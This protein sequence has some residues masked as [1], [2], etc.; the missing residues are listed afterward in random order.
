M[1]LV[2]VISAGRAVKQDK[3]RFGE[4]AILETL[5]REGPVSKMRERTVEI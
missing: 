5:V 1:C 3:M 2:V 4:S